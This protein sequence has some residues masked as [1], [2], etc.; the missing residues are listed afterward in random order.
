V[1]VDAAFLRS[2][3]RRRLLDLAQQSHSPVAIVHCRAPD[4]V[5]RQRVAAR[6]ATRTD[7]SEAGLDVLARQP[8]YWEP[9]DAREQA[10]VLEVDTSDPAAVGRAIVHLA[11]LAGR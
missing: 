9:F 11:M 4:A 2:G 5:L 10:C 1:I 3:E 6:S 7:A 8:A